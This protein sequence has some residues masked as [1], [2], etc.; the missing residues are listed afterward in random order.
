MV[1]PLLAGQQHCNGRAGLVLS[2]G[3]GGRSSTSGRLVRHSF[4]F[5]GSLWRWCCTG[6][7]RASRVRAP[8]MHQRPTNSRIAAVNLAMCALAEYV[9][10]YMPAAVYACL[11]A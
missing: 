4:W 11:T 9:H 10:V 6:L 8:F 2:V 7:V 3:G 5:Y 1:C